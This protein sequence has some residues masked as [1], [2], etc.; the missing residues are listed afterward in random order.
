MVPPLTAVP[1]GG[2]VPNRVVPSQ[3]AATFALPPFFALELFLL[4]L[5]PHAATPSAATIRSAQVANARTIGFR[6]VIAVVPPSTSYV[7]SGSR[8]W[9][10]RCDPAAVSSPAT[11]TAQPPHVYKSNHTAEPM[12]FPINRFPTGD[13]TF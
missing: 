4:E 13:A 2:N 1:S 3:L 5:E 12:S 6:R 9:S 8:G 11:D 7:I 10:P